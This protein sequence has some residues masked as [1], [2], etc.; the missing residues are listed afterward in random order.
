VTEAIVLGDFDDGPDVPA[1]ITGVDLGLRALDLVMHWKRCG[2]TADWLAGFVAYDCDPAARGNAVGVLSTIVNEL[3]E[4]A[5]KFCADKTAVVGV[6]VHHHGEFV[7]VE[8]RN[9][10]D[11]RRVAAF[12]AAL[13]DLATSPLDD[14]FAKRIER[15]REPGSPGIGLLLLK[16]DY[17][18]RIGVRLDARGDA[19]WDVRVRVA[20]QTEEIEHP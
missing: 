2:M 4:N 12:R 7:R 16:K 8:T 15:A 20:I 19:R 6:A 11:A 5:A 1:A 17:G 3:L 13:D 9:V 18:A 14:L 10:A